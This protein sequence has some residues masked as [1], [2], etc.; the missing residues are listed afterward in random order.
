MIHVP[1]ENAH[2]QFWAYVR[3]RQ[4]EQVA[5]ARVLK[6][7]LSQGDTYLA[8][9]PAFGT[10]SLRV[11]ATRIPVA[12]SRQIE[13]MYRDLPTL[14]HVVEWVKQIGW[15]GFHSQWQ[16][17]VTDGKRRPIWI[18]QIVFPDDQERQ[19]VWR[20]AQGIEEL[21]G[22]LQ[23]VADRLPIAIAH[24]C[25]HLDPVQQVAAKQALAAV[26]SALRQLEPSPVTQENA[27]RGPS[28]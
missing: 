14:D 7:G 17:T 10:A 6:A 12:R 8:M 1:D 22:A 25:E 4:K 16:I 19:E 24:A 13:R 18:D 28:S 23:Q 2:P 15:D 27:L 9:G 21:R 5:E 20:R 3:A 26:R 11:V